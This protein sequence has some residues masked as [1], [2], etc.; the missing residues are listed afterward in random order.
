MIRFIK[1]THTLVWALMVSAILY[2]LY[3]GLTDTN[4]IVLWLSI[5]LILSEGVVLL[6][7]KWSCP[8]TA[9]A[10]KYTDNRKDNFD[11]YLPN[12]VAKYKRTFF[13]A[14]F[15]IGIILIIL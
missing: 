3:C 9:V 15:I 7:N 6:F 10:A 11:I 2:I 1:I 14:L 5:V 13:T 8:F 4:N 12:M